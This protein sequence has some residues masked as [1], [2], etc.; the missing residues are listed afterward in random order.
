MPLRRR[1]VAVTLAALLASTSTSTSTSTTTSAH[2]DAEVLPRIQP[3][4]VY[5]RQMVA[6]HTIKID[7]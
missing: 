2:I 3:D 4:L 6:E 7:Q 5:W 1:A